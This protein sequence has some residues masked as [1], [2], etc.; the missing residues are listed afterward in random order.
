MVVPAA[1]H[2]DI[3]LNA[4]D[5]PALAQTSWESVGDWW[6]KLRGCASQPGAVSTESPLQ[7]L[8]S[9]CYYP[10]GAAEGEA[11]LQLADLALG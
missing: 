6:N 3:S 7:P 10:K 2:I 11:A 1:K 5:A 4:C 8:H 9:Y